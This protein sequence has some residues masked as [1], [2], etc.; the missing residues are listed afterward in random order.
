MY[1]D[2][3]IDIFNDNEND[4]FFIIEFGMNKNNKN[5]WIY[6]WNVKCNIKR[7]I[8]EGLCFVVYAWDIGWELTLDYHK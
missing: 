4:R 3:I 6:K 2:A 1:F 7:A 5:L 8:K